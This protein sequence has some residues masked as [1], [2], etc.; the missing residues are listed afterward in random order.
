MGRD[1]EAERPQHRVTI[2]RPFALSQTEITAAD[3]QACVH[4]N[5]CAA[6]PYVARD[7]SL[8]AVNITRRDAA[9]YI[10]WLN[11]TVGGSAYRLPSEAEWEYAARGNAAGAA[12][13]PPYP[14]GRA[15]DHNRANFKGTGGI[16]IWDTNS[17]PAMSFPANPFGLYQMHG[18]VGEYV[19]DCY[20]LSHAG[21]PADGSARLE[22]DGDCSYFV[23][24]GGDRTDEASGIRSA[25]REIAT[26]G[27]SG[28]WTGLRV[29]RDLIATPQPAP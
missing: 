18:N 9:R 1:A 4:A 27:N 15:A 8:P 29:A 10:A 6:Q 28:S 2:A 24:K 26:S 22:R 25:A 20:S 11:K 3:Y 5:A 7:M 14:W 12:D 23:T 21:A 19:A 16:D 17:A 13:D